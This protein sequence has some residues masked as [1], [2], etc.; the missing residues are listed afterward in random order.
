[1][2]DHDHMNDHQAPFVWSRLR[3]RYHDPSCRWVLKI[4]PTNWRAGDNPEPLDGQPRSPCKV[5]EPSPAAIE[6]N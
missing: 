3:K 6:A 4:L 1:M 2:I 5:C